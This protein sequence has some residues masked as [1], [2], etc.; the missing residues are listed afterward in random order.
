MLDQLPRAI[1]F[2]L[3][4]TILMDSN[5]VD[6][7]WLS[8]CHRCASQTEALKPEALFAAIQEYRAWF[9]SDPE[10][11][12]RGRLDLEAARRDIVAGALLQLDIE[13]P[14][15]ASA[16]AQAYGELRDEDAQPFPDAL[17]TLRLLRKRDIRLALITNGS[18]R[19]QRRK[20]EKYDLA[21]FFDCVLIEGEFGI[22]KP[23]E[24]VYLH[25]LSQ[26]E[27]PPA[28]AWMVGDNLEWE[29]AAPQQLGIFAIWHDVAGTG[30]PASSKVRPD[31][32]IRALSEL[33]ELIQA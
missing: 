32:I 11:H 3:D 27:T 2:D 1:L 10:R 8:A 5:N 4:D 6:S 26:L 21:A 9:W 29:V 24:R 20:I 31:R 18:A 13:H 33:I 15:L 30:L 25:A 14:S 28:R 16:I 22:G 19:L 12:R 7:C 17:D 23:D